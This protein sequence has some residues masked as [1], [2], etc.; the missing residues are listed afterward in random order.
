MKTANDAYNPTV[1]SPNELEASPDSRREVSIWWPA[2]KPTSQ[3]WWFLLWT[4]IGLAGL[5]EILRH[6]GEDVN[7]WFVESALG[8]GLCVF[9]WYVTFVLIRFVAYWFSKDRDRKM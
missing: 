5:R 6:K 9:S 3:L 1:P 7:D 8:V 2:R 4:I